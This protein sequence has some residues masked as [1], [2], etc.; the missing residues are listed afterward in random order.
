MLWKL[1]IVDFLNILLRNP[2]VV[3]RRYLLIWM[4]VS[5]AVYALEHAEKYKLTMLSDLPV[6]GLKLTLFLI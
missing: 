5:N 6:V 3:T 4:L 1:M 2:I